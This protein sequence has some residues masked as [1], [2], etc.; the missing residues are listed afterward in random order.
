MIIIIIIKKK[1]KKRKNLDRH[2]PPKIKI[3]TN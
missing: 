2:N 1:E 3:V